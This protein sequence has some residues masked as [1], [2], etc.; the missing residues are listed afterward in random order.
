MYT[1]QKFNNDWQ[2]WHSN[3]FKNK[4]ELN[5]QQTRIILKRPWTF[6]RM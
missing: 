5:I 3:F 4:F 6:G 2:R 1:K